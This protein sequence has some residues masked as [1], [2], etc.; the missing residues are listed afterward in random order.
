MNEQ[1][2]ETI[3]KL[4]EQK[5]LRRKKQPHCLKTMA[6]LEAILGEDF[7]HKQKQ[8]GRAP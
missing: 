7:I 6:E 5:Y 1:H 4:E 8:M 2:K 3:L